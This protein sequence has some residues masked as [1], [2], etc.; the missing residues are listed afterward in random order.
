MRSHRF[1]ALQDPQAGKMWVSGTLLSSLCI[2]SATSLIRHPA[3]PDILSF[4]SFGGLKCHSSIV[5]EWLI[6]GGSVN[7][8]TTFTTF[9]QS[10][11]VTWSLEYIYCKTSW[12]YARNIFTSRTILISPQ[13]CFTSTLTA[14]MASP[15]PR[16]REKVVWE[17]I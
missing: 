4:T 16:S 3:E 11:N 15:T 1:D 2:L 13:W 6:S 12:T 7:Q 10:I 17:W 5:G 8:C 9:V 14:R